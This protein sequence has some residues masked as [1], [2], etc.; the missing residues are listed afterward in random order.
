MDV[1][2]AGTKMPKNDSASATRNIECACLVQLPPSR[3]RTILPFAVS[4]GEALRLFSLFREPLPDGQAEVVPRCSRIMARCRAAAFIASEIG[5]TP[6]R[7][8]AL[9]PAW[10]ASSMT[11]PTVI[12]KSGLR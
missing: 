1:A 10:A 7:P 5:T 4:G 2:E 3:P 12:A 8:I 6:P 11:L 9:I